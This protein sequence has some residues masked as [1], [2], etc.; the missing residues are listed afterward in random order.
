MTL[1]ELL[2]KYPD[3]DLESNEGDPVFRRSVW[4]AF[5]RNLYVNKVI[6]REKFICLARIDDLQST[7]GG[8]RGTV[9]PLRFL[10]QYPHLNTPSRP[11]R[12]GGSWADMWQG[13]HTLGQPYA[14]WTI[15]PEEERVRAIEALL[16]KDDV[17]EA[18]ELIRGSS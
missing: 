18:L 11:W 17:D 16:A 8:V 14:G 15:W 12:F 2:Q 13:E 4:E 3:R 1:K 7:E 9:V 10:F 5:F 6:Y